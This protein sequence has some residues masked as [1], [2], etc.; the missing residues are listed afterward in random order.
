MGSTQVLLGT[1]EKKR[2]N[3][4]ASLR[5]RS[6]AR[7]LNTADGLLSVKNDWQVLFYYREQKKKDRV[8]RI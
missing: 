7:S 6:R 5:V 1:E 3:K 8:T 2:K 4:G